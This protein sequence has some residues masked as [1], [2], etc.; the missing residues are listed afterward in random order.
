MADKDHVTDLWKKPDHGQEEGCI[1]SHEYKYWKP[2]HPNCAYRVKGRAEIAGNPAKM[3][4][5]FKKPE[6]AFSGQNYTVAKEPFPHQYHHIMP[7]GVLLG[8]LENEELTILQASRYNINEGINLIILPVIEKHAKKLMLP[9]HS[10]SHPKY[11][12]DCK[13]MVYLLRSDMAALTA[14]KKHDI[15]EANVKGFRDNLR[16]WEQNEFW[17]LVGYG[18]ASMANGVTPHINTSGLV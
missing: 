8:E 15:T 2:D 17:L 9:I 6:W 16:T 13:S 10:G 11:N 3:E 7:S 1:S 12:D 18:K 14:D 5:Y 4:L